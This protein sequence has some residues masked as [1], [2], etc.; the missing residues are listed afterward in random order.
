MIRKWGLLLGLLLLFFPLATMAQHA[1]T[2][3]QCR[4]DRDL[5]RSELFGAEH[6]FSEGRVSEALSRISFKDLSERAYELHLCEKVVDTA[7]KLESADAVIARWENI[8]KYTSLVERYDVEQIRRL[9]AFMQTNK[10]I[11]AFLQDDDLQTKNA[12]AHKP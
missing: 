8:G 12:N 2:Q 11:S 7:P 3:E 9:L 5:W 6:D 4:A 1:P 10:L